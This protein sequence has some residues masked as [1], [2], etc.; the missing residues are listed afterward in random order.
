MTVEQWGEKISVPHLPEFTVSHPGTAHQHPGLDA[1]PPYPLLS[2]LPPEKS[3]QAPHISIHLTPLPVSLEQYLSSVNLIPTC[4]LPLP[5]RSLKPLQSFLCSGNFQR[6]LQDLQGLPCPHPHRFFSLILILS[7]PFLHHSGLFSDLPSPCL[8]LPWSLCKYVLFHLEFCHF[9]PVS[10][11]QVM[12]PAGSPGKPSRIH[13]RLLIG[14]FDVQTKSNKHWKSNRWL[15]IRV[16]EELGWNLWQRKDTR[17]ATH[18]TRLE[19]I[20]GL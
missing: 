12:A 11:S 20:L 10:S 3:L 8:L 1:P 9:P 7:Y 16:P 13:W 17:W 2:F 19:A 6:D 14:G 15:W 4:L 18:W 5:P